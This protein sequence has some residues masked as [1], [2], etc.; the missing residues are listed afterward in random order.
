MT[1]QDSPADSETTRSS[2][3]SLVAIVLILIALVGA[4]ISA[5]YSRKLSNLLRQQNEFEK[6]FGEMNVEDPSKVA[7][8]AVSP[9]ATELPVWVA[10]EDIW[11]FRVHIPENYGVSFSTTTGMIA[12]D[13]PLS[14][15]SGGGSASGGKPEASEFL[16]T[17]STSKEDGRL[18]VNLFGSSG[19][20]SLSLPKELALGS[21][22]DFVLDMIASP[23]DPM[24]TFDAD[25][26][27]CIWKLRT[28]TPS[29]KMLNNT[30]LYPSCA[31]YMY[32]KARRD[33]FRR[34]ERGKT[35]SMK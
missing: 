21:P 4:F 1:D 28:K 23:G 17:V 10:S 16:L 22:D 13:S 35:S 27:I 24:Q 34:W 33:A 30:K 15:S 5:G 12:A 20:S 2:R 26:A 9:T 19:S 29:D 11:S 18:K 8:V 14:T 25:E 7:I 31:I 3:F 32:E 6:L